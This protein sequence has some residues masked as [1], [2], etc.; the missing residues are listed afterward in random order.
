MDTTPG[1]LTSRPITRRLGFGIAATAV[2]AGLAPA[3]RADGRRRRTGVDTRRAF[4]T[5][6]YIESSR[7]PGGYGARITYGSV[8]AEF[9]P[10]GDRLLV[11]GPD[12]GTRLQVNVGIYEKADSDGVPYELIEVD[13]LNLGRGYH[14]LN[15]GTP[16][17]SGN[18]AEGRRIE[19]TM[20]LQYMTHGSPPAY[21]IA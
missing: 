3:A 10:Y 17:S 6:S 9:E 14:D 21:G 20:K 7:D 15:L 8:S 18:I 16:D 11:K 19:I 2:L 12:D 4:D 13:N 1:S 5:V